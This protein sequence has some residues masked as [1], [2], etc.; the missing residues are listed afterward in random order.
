[1]QAPSM[2]RLDVIFPVLIVALS[3]ALALATI[4]Q[5]PQFHADDAYIVARYA[6]YLVRH[7]QLVWN[8]GEAPVEGFTGYTRLSG[9]T[10]A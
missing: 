4:I 2:K 9:M 6:D 3:A 5:G 1:M 8:V 7:G 10:I